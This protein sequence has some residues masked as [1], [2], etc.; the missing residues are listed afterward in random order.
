[1][2]AELPVIANQHGAVKVLNNSVHTACHVLG[3]EMF[4]T[5]SNLF[6]RGRMGAERGSF[7]ATG[8][9]S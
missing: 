3:V 1:M 9:K 5:S 6:G 8:T 4:K 7:S 2:K